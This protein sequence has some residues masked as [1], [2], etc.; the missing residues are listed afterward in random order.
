MSATS[1]AGLRIERCGGED[2]LAHVADLWRLAE[3]EVARAVGEL[4]HDRHIAPAI[5]E[6]LA[7]L[8][9]EPVGAAVVGPFYSRPADFEGAWTTLM[10]RDDVR[11]QGIG[12]ALLAVNAEHAQAMGKSAMYT[13]ASEGRP[14]TLEFLRNRGF[15]EVERSKHAALE[16]AGLERPEVAP[17][18]GMEITTLAERPD[19]A[20]AVYEVDAEAVRDIPGEQPLEAV[21]YDEWRSFS[22]DAPGTPAEA[23]FI[24][25]ADGEAV[26]WASLE[27][28]AARAGVAVHHMT[29]VKRAWRGR[30]VASALKRATIAWALANGLEVLE[31]E[32]DDANAPMRAVNRRLGYRPLPDRLTMRAPLPGP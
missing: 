16:L 8:D 4:L 7:W 12:S 26:G 28:L 24:A 3:P 18:P 21:A 6:Y 32:N 10:V 19:L 13:Y 30:G 27:L 2:D 5:R 15:A 25:L 17:P 31:T 22:L 9:G 23:C 29:G 1:P 20:R 14:A 11:R